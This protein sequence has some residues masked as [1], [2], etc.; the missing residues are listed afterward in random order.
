MNHQSNEESCI[1]GKSA[2]PSVHQP[3]TYRPQAVRGYQGNPC[4]EALPDIEDPLAAAQRLSRYPPY[5][6]DD[7]SQPDHLRLHI[8]WDTLQDL[9][10]CDD[11]HTNLQSQVGLLI[12]AGYKGRN[13]ADSGYW[14]ALG[15]NLQA[16]NSLGGNRLGLAAKALGLVGI[17]GGGKSTTLQHLLALYPQVIQHTW[18]QG[19]SLTI[20]QL[21]WLKL[22]CPSDGSTKGLC[23]NFLNAVDGLLAT[24]YQSDFGGSRRTKYELL[25]AMARIAAIHCLGVLVVDEIQVLSQSKSGGADEMLNF[26]VELINT[27][28]V[29]IIFV[30]TYQAMPVLSGK[31]R[32]ARRVSGYGDCVWRPMKEDAEWQFFVEALWKYTYVR[33]PGP[34]TQELRHALYEETQ[35][36]ADLAVKVYALAQ[37][38]AITSK[39]E[40]I[41]EPIIRSVALDSLQL[42]RRLINALKVGDDEQ[43]RKIGDI[44]PV[45]MEDL[46]QRELSPD[47]TRM[48]PLDGGD[49]ASAQRVPEAEHLAGGG[50]GGEVTDGGKPGE[51]IPSTT[52]LIVDHIKA[53]KSLNRVRRQRPKKAKKG[54]VSYA[55]GSLMAIAA[56]KESL[57]PQLPI[58]DRLCRAGV[59]RPVEK[60]VIGG[61]A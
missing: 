13:P 25:P 40:S 14:G 8:I 17:S 47:K 41:T 42:S 36:I 54:D 35:G 55:A 5:R 18:Y 48:V 24:T 11:R 38:R 10:I 39:T 2:L 1:V 57:E 58:Y 4:N 12:R 60:F 34:L 27:I 23:N 19:R 51:A 44:V 43:V 33:K 30:G 46:L 21:V 61:L 37:W 50:I 53:T 7:C 31:F 26:F 59:M 16:F 6:K 45:D 56:E 52:D 32:Q 15:K 9:F 29:P 3:A 49:Q 22:E 20:D 28:G